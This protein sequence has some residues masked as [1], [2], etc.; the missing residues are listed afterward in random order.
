MAEE[1]EYEIVL[2]PE[3]EGG[4]SVFVPELPSVATQ[5]ETAEEAKSMAREAIEAYL[6]VMR[7]DGLPLP[8]VQR[9]RVAVDA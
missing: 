3:P 2:Q 5:G 6:E 4:F 9:S 8:S 1:R 7:E